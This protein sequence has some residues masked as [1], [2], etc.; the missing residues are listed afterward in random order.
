LPVPL[1]L[2]ALDRDIQLLEYLSPAASVVEIAYLDQIV[3]RI[4]HL[5]ANTIM[6]PI[7]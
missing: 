5:A 6:L 4:I 2:P 7:P 1:N 3:G